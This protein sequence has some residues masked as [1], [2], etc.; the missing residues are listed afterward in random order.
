MREKHPPWEN[1]NVLIKH[2]IISQS[3]S[4]LWHWRHKAC[5]FSGDHTHV[6]VGK[7]RFHFKIFSSHLFVMFSASRQL[8]FTGGKNFLN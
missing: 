7:S 5:K 8:V 3:T 1:I 6:A 4:E 2:G